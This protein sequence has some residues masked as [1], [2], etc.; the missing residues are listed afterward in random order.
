MSSTTKDPVW[1]VVVQISGEGVTAAL[2]NRK[3]FRKSIETGIPWI[4]HP[5][6][7]RVLPWPGE[8]Q[9][10]SLSESSGCFLLT[11]PAG[12]ILEP[13]GTGTPPEVN[14]DDRTDMEE[15]LTSETGG[16]EKNSVMEQLS[17]LIAQR[18]NT[19][20]EGSYTTHLFEQGLDKILK[21]TG[22][23]AVELLLARN[24]K[25]VIYESADLVYHLLVLLEASGLSWSEV[26]RE[27]S[28]RH[29]G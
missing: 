6:T 20:P 13:Y 29:S 27:L 8:P 17:T 22:E 9:S 28:R 16:M 25:D 23:E 7:E 26:T 4:V 19:M 12:S 14:P 24:D 1:P 10:L 5:E 11:L 2:M 18:H 21:K 15:T 3:A